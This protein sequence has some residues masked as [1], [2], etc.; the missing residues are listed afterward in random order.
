VRIH[1]A[2]AR[3]EIRRIETPEAEMF[4]PKCSREAE[5]NNAEEDLRCKYVQCVSAAGVISGDDDYAVATRRRRLL[6]TP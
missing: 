6:A 2:L 3:C 4:Q 5:I 1:L